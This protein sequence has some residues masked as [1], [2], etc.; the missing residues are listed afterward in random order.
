MT[1]EKILIIILPKTEPTAIADS[2]NSSRVMKTIPVIFMDLS[3]FLPLGIPFLIRYVPKGSPL[4]ESLA[5][6]L[7]IVD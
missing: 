6:G 7:S 3:F 1:L 5:L 4:R 2:I